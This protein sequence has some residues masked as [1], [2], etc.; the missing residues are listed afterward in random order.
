MSAVQQVCD[1]TQVL[2]ARL[3]RHGVVRRPVVSHC[4]LDLLQPALSLLSGLRFEIVGAAVMRKPNW[5][6]VG[7]SPPAK[8]QGPAV[9]M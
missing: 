8:V 4:D 9:S 6:A 7:L 3:L 2:F 5:V 1:D